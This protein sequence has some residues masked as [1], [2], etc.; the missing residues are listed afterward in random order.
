MAR[1][2]NSNS[3]FYPD[4]KRLFASCVGKPLKY[5][6]EQLR[7][8]FEAY[9]ADLQANPIYSDTSI[10]KKS[11][12]GSEEKSVVNK[13]PKPPRMND[14]INRWLGADWRWW[15]ELSKSKRGEEYSII[16]AHIKD[17]CEGAMLD[18]AMCGIYKENLVSRYLGLAEHTE[19]AITAK[20]Q[21]DMNTRY[22]VE[23]IP[24]ELLYRL[25][26][27]MQDKANGKGKENNGK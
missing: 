20:Q 12:A 22:S 4:I 11:A 24:E 8:E 9:I 16:K 2:S 5:T 26:D 10:R 13:Y 23:D 27:A 19:N 6:P 18:G 25:A 1:K 7:E 21:V 15:A 17:Y 3:A 14:F